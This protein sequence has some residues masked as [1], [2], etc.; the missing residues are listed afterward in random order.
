MNFLYYFFRGVALAEFM[1]ILCTLIAS[2]YPTFAVMYL[3]WPFY[4]SL[5]LYGVLPCFLIWGLVG[6]VFGYEHESA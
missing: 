3:A 2:L 6:F 4:A 5:Q 1:I